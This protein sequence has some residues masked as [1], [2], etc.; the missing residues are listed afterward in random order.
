MNIS[1]Q[2]DIG[3]YIEGKSALLGSQVVAG[4]GG[5]GLEQDGYW[6]DRSRRLSGVLMITFTAVLAE[7]ATLSIGANLQDASDSAGTGAADFGDAIASAVVATGG[8]GGSTEIG[9]VELDVD[10]S[11]ADAFVRGQITPTLSAASIDTVDISAVL[12][13]SGGDEY[14]L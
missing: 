7:D 9:T 2:R 4:A 3:A 11:G 8:S 14:P 1:Q 12:V 13:L 5:D 10:L 6:N